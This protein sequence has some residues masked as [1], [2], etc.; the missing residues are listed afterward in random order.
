M[1]G[2]SRTS[3]AALAVCLSGS[4]F[5]FSAQTP[6]A[7][8][9]DQ[10]TQQADGQFPKPTPQGLEFKRLTSID[11]A[12]WQVPDAHFHWLLTRISQ[13]IADKRVMR[14]Y[15][16]ARQRLIPFTAAVPLNWRDAAWDRVSA[17]RTPAPSGNDAATIASMGRWIN[18]GPTTIPG[19]VTGL[20]R[21][22]KRPN[23]LLAAMADGGAWRSR[24]NGLT[25]EPLSE[26]EATLASGAIA[27][28]PVD[29][30]TFYW[31]PGEG[32]G[33][34]DNY[35]GI[36]VLR[37][38]D[39]GRSWSRSNSFSGSF[40]GLTVN[41][42]NRAE[43]WAAGDR[44]FRSTDSGATF[45][46][47]NGGTPEN[48]AVTVV[49]HPTD[50]SKIL[51]SFWGPGLYKSVDSGAT[52]VPMN[53]GLPQG[54]GRTEVALCASNP[55]VIY[56]YG[57]VGAGDMWKTTD[58]GASWTA[59]F[60]TGFDPCGGQC[61]FDMSL[62]VAPDDCN[63][64]YFGGVDAFTSRNGGTTWTSVGAAGSSV[65]VDHH[66]M[67]VGPAGEV[68]MGSD[69]GV[70][71][72]TDWG[73]TFQ[74]IGQGLPTT[75]Y[76]GACGSDVE[77]GYLFGGTQDNGS[78]RRRDSDG[79]AWLLGGDG[80]MCA[81]GGNKILGEYQNTSLTR[82]VDGGASWQDANGG[83]DSH[84]PRAWV[85]I[86]EK[87]PLNANTLY[88]GTNKVYRTLD[89]KNTAWKQILGPIYYSRQVTAL[90]VSPADR[91]VLWVGFDL[92]GLYRTTQ[93]T[94]T[95]TVAFQNV[96]RDLP[97]RAIRRVQPHPTDPN[98]AWIL[99]SGY[100][101]PKLMFT[102]N[103]GGSYVDKTGDLPDVPINDL[104]IDP[105]DSNVLL[106]ATDLGVLRS[107]DGGA[108][109]FGFSD[110]L[111]AVA[112][113][114]MFRHPADG[115]VIA[116]THGRSMYRFRPAATAAVAVPD[117]ASVA[118]EMLRAQRTADNRLWLSWDTKSCTAESYHL[119]FGELAQVA[120]GAYS[121]ANCNLP[122]SGVTI[123]DLPGA[124][125]SSMYFLM[126]GATATGAEG[127]HGFDSTGAVR[128]N[129][130]V[131][132]CGI[133]SHSAAASCP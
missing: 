113:I 86:I 102:N 20:A 17:S 123:V 99:L 104:V 45:S 127:P 22:A 24:D 70:F 14:Q 9:A 79:W 55:D 68:V 11:P 81:V 6:S 54:T 100:G 131:G 105:G 129:S 33:A 23:E 16:W 94:S 5:P 96:K 114:E 50:P 21:P 27:A 107:D 121:G 126:A 62:K 59:L 110:G 28:D 4:L 48:G 36:G 106:A 64:V 89:F 2:L 35:G 19:R 90:A 109:W 10:D 39:G 111:P 112:V 85:G 3:F 115:T 34:I 125:G 91:N 32:N 118:G 120:T 63:T 30:A 73:H 92:G 84:D 83:I 60:S 132:L 58:G 40:R 67:L 88:V 119:F 26:R 69:G 101:N 87:D 52:W 46:R 18:V 93:A 43:V 38:Q 108:H 25:W 12:E 128:P 117:G 98:T 1:S 122:R 7:T 72:S 71:R 57:E 95:G 61:W 8:T 75:Q 56:V 124:S 97:N 130:G 42:H 116:G 80:G 44:L 53:N 78:H 49:V 65:H 74:S 82:S 51:A 15:Y 29:P 41:P 133:T 66:T 37:T 77:S 76:Y 31:G 47:V 103:A 13:G